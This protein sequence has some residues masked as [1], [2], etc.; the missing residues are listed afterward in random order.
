MP[1]ICL[2]TAQ[3]VKFAEVISEALGREPE[4]PEHSRGLEQLSQRVE[5]IAADAAAV[6]RYIEARCSQAIPT[7]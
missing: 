2:E 6:K 5:I 4:C 3:P 7:K 1:L